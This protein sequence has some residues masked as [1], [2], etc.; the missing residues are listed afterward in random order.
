MS[1][2]SA[3]DR[4]RG[5][6]PRHG[7]PMHLE[8]Q[9]IFKDPVSLWVLRSQRARVRARLVGEHPPERSSEAGL[10]VILGSA[11]GSY[12]VL[13]KAAVPVCVAGCVSVLCVL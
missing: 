7:D 12:A 1:K 5:P 8:P 9:L 6:G 3:S 13:V 11:L 4:G 2:V 10:S